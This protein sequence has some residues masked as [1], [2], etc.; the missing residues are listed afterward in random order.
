MYICVFSNVLSVGFDLPLMPTI[1]TLEIPIGL[2]FFFAT[3]F[4][5]LNSGIELQLLGGER[6]GSSPVA[7]TL[8]VA[9]LVSSLCTSRLTAQLSSLKAVSQAFGCADSSPID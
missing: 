1:W 6:S 3:M 9:R 8:N 2:E 7:P 5:R 4:Q